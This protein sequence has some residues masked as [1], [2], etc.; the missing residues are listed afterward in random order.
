M[1]QFIY[2]PFVKLR[3]HASLMQT[4]AHSTMHILQIESQDVTVKICGDT[5]MREFNKNY[6]GIDQTTD[7]LSFSLEFKE[8][9]SN[10]E[11]LGDIV[12]SYPAAKKQAQEHHQSLEDELTF[13][14][15]HG[16]LHLMGHDHD[17]LEDERKMFS[18]QENLFKQVLGKYE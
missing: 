5:E 11:Y 15:I 12:I 4:R 3:I 9:Q 8:P 2:S 16:L 1:I 17:K 13:L 14:L 10:A 6:R 7:V 18:L